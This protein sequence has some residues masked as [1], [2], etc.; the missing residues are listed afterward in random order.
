MTDLF[1]QL[2]DVS[3]P[4]LKETVQTLPLLLFFSLKGFLRWFQILPVLVV[5]V[6]LEV[7]S[8]M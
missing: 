8:G 2:V 4:L 1:F 3:A 5:V 6:E 7:I